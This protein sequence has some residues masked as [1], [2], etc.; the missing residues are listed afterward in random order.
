MIILIQTLDFRDRSL[1][2]NLVS[3]MIKKVRRRQQLIMKDLT[4]LDRRR[5]RDRKLEKI[6]RMLRLMFKMLLPKICQIKMKK[7]IKAL[8][9][10]YRNHK[11][12][13]THHSNKNELVLEDS[14]ILLYQ[15]NVKD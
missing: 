8:Q 13:M 1:R 7:I 2:Y 15:I 9:R 4:Q 6:S 14:K 5:L 11:L 10:K 12:K 3:R